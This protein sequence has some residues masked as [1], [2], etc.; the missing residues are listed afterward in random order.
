MGLGPG[1][2][3]KEICVPYI[4]YSYGEKAGREDIEVGRLLVLSPSITNSMPKELELHVVEDLVP[5]FS[6]KN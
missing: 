3:M 2:R 4:L 5:Y 1:S 6:S